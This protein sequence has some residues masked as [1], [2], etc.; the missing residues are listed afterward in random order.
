[1]TESCARWMVACGCNPVV[2]ACNTASGAALDHVRS[3]FPD[4]S[5]VGMEPAVK[6]AA[7]STQT[8]VVGVLATATTFISP[9]YADLIRR[10]AGD[11]RVIERAC[12]GWVEFVESG[13]AR[14]GAAL[15][16][17][18]VTS[19]LREGADVLVL[20]CTHFPFLKAEIMGA[21]YAWHTQHPHS[22]R[23]TLIDPAPAVAH[24]TL[25][26]WGQLT[27]MAPDGSV[28]AQP[29]REFW[30]TGDAEDF[31][32]VA[33]DLIGHKYMDRAA[34]GRAVVH[35]RDARTRDA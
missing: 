28:R 31:C 33:S 12:H 18:Y 29:R 9:R 13:A 14:A 15:D 3:T 1:L 35:A 11:V 17:S 10:F 21:A 6:P 4:T 27:G 25:R 24:Q 22:A 26:V 19:L 2:I 34:V 8:G 16:T 7:L 30:T 20:G 5:F 23:A 32:R